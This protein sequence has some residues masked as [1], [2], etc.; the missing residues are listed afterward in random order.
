MRPARDLPNVDNNKDRFLLEMLGGILK[1]RHQHVLALVAGTVVSVV[2]S[3]DAV[4]CAGYRAS[5]EGS[6]HSG[7][8]LGAHL[9]HTLTHLAL[10]TV[11]VRDD[12]ASSLRTDSPGP[13]LPATSSHISWS[14]SALTA[15]STLLKVL[16][17]PRQPANRPARSSQNS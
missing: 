14:A 8:V 11:V 12:G 3:P 16:D 15:L 13:S 6:Q 10:L 7:V 1:L 4:T 17:G 2:A 9:M 5:S